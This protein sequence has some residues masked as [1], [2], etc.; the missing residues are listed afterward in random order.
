MQTSSWPE[1]RK[2]KNIPFCECYA[3]EP[4]VNEDEKL[5]G[6]WIFNKFEYF[7]GDVVVVV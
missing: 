3:L 7:G 5:I 4:C 2:I 1:G 6:N